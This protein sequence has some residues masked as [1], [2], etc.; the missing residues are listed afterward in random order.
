MEPERQVDVELDLG[1]LSR[2]NLPPSRVLQAIG[3]ESADFP[4]GRVEAGARVFNVRSSGS[5]ESPEQVA[6]TVVG[7]NDGRLIRVGDVAEV[8]WGYADSTYRA[9]YDGRRAVF[10]TVTQQDGQNIG[11]IRDRVW[12]AL[13]ARED[14]VPERLPPASSERGKQLVA[15]AE[16]D[17]LVAIDLC[18]PVRRV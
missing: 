8:T 17:A 13:D 4:A 18:V 14:L 2:L 5:Y 10:L 15:A 9:R 1:R 12:A 7:G 16:L 6:A 3:G 11:V